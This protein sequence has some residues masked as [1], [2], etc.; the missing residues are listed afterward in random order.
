[1]K[2][3]QAFDPRCNALNAMRLA[4][5]TEV[6]VFHSIPLTGHVLQS[7]SAFR[8]LFS[9]GVDGFFALSGFLITASWLRNPRVRDY[10]RAR[11]LR[12]LPAYYVCLVATA[13]IAAPLSLLIQGESPLRLLMSSAPVEY[14]LKNIG[15][16][17]LQ[18]GIDGTP[19]GVPFAGIWN[20]SLW[21]LVFE[22]ACYVA[23]AVLGVLG[24][25]H[26]RWTSPVIFALATIGA[27]MLP[28]LVFT[29]VWTIPQLAVRAAIMFAAGAM[30]YQWQDKIPAR[31]SLVALSVAVVLVSGLL[32]DYRVVGAFPLA[33]AV[34]VAG[35]LIKH[36]RMVLR[37]DLSY[38]VY[39]YA[40][41]IQQLLSV[42]GLYHLHPLPFFV[43]SMAAVLP[44]AALSWFVVEKR[45]L[46]WKRQLGQRR[47]A[48][49]QPA[50]DS[51]DSKL[52]RRSI[53]KPRLD[54]S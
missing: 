38:G 9:V 1:M 45:A 24:L 11:A 42:A 32:P 52:N 46:A 18:A 29:E 7:E 43:V 39:V 27:I 34:V 41:P 54:A 5:A 31:W 49:D 2:L 13:F 48:P 15:L 3:G 53:L 40:F 37:T 26:R 36:R 50:R 10:L 33:Y 16:I 6:I 25:A 47:D 17:Q 12:I 14:V 20:G 30:L 21:S 28:P 8:L 44:V 51:V 22:A 19:R 35:V 4:L 23:V